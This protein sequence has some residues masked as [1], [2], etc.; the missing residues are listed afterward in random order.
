MVNFPPSQLYG[1]DFNFEQNINKIEQDL[2]KVIRMFR[3]DF[4][5][6]Q[7]EIIKEV[8]AN[9]QF[10]NEVLQR[11]E[12]F[13]K[14]ITPIL[15]DVEKYIIDGTFKH[16]ANNI[17]SSLSLQEILKETRL[18]ASNSLPAPEILSNDLSI[19]CNLLENYEELTSKHK[20][21]LIDSKLGNIGSIKT[22]ILDTINMVFAVKDDLKNTNIHLST[23][24]TPHCF[25]NREIND[26]QALQKIQVKITELPELPKMPPL[27]RIGRTPSKVLIKRMQ[28]QCET[29]KDVL[30]WHY[31]R[32]LSNQ[33]FFDPNLPINA[34][35]AGIFTL[36]EHIDA[37]QKY[38]GNPLNLIKKS[39]L[40][41][42]T[43]M[44]KEVEQIYTHHLDLE[45][46]IFIRDYVS[47]FLKECGRLHEK[48]KKNIEN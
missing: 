37:F 22:S 5:D 45:D 17:L 32:A 28:M 23:Y 11:N 21:A 42:C 29:L 33:D 26:E 7:N 46:Q 25:G 8:W 10:K 6:A 3:P 39:Y 18:S 15:D 13:I 40:A 1:T 38:I 47:A 16:Y 12:K 41:Q 9:Q 35:E 34:P 30:R 31:Q 36:Y 24:T 2:L 4:E 20:F 43:D 19:F 27:V 48:L 14:E 44:A